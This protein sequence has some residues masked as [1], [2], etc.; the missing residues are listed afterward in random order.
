MGPNAERMTSAHE[1]LQVSA[2]VASALQDRPFEA[3]VS[4]PLELIRRVHVDS[5]SRLRLFDV[6]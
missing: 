6:I 4:C 2:A 5:V 1:A 3:D